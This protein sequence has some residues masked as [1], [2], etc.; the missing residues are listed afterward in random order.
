MGLLR[1]T[2]QEKEHARHLLVARQDF[3]NQENEML[4]HY[5]LEMH[6]SFLKDPQATK[7]LTMED[8]ENLLEKHAGPVIAS[9]HAKSGTVDRE[10]I[11]AYWKQCGL[12]KKS[13]SQGDDA[14]N[15]ASNPPRRK[16][17][18]SLGE[19]E[20]ETY[21]KAFAAQKNNAARFEGKPLVSQ[22]KEKIRFRRLNSASPDYVQHQYALGM[23][24]THVSQRSPQASSR[25]LPHVRQ[26]SPQPAAP[27]SKTGASSNNESHHQPSDQ[28][29]QNNSTSTRGASSHE[30][31]KQ[32][33]SNQPRQNKSISTHRGNDESHQQAPSNQ[34]PQQNKSTS[35]TRGASHH[36][37]Q[38][39][40]PPKP[41]TTTT[42]S[43]SSSLLGPPRYGSLSGDHFA[44]AHLSL[45]QMPPG[46]DSIFSLN[47]KRRDEMVEQEQRPKKVMKRME[48]EEEG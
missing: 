23:G 45:P 37:H 43:S 28:A 30:S 33:P 34:V 3:D 29:R 44:K 24:Y 47:K 14:K 2:A 7:Q 16:R 9:A 13:W 41:T 20:F 11:D 32:A 42:G 31:H 26:P 36:D 5:R 48:G 35:N 1:L 18:G 21:T 22:E 6:A 27:S 46:V 15:T 25:R 39:P 17:K 12:D 19:D 8:K 40:K 10:K 38:H 4:S